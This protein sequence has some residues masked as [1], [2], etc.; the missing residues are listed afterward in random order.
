MIMP[1]RGWRNQK[2][3][4]R[5]I[6]GSARHSSRTGPSHPAAMLWRQCGLLSLRSPGKRASLRGTENGRG[7]SLVVRRLETVHS[8]IYRVR[9]GWLLWR[10]FTLAVVVA[11]ETLLG[12]PAKLFYPQPPIH[13]STSYFA[14]VS[15]LSPRSPGS[16]PFFSIQPPP[17]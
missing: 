11:V 6:A 4:V 7:C 12:P 15:T 13:T 1:A 3:P 5:L 2:D 8:R 14:S 16:P 17:S 9:C 10:S